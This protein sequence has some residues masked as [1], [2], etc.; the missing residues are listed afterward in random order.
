[1]GNRTD[2]L[3]SRAKVARRKDFDLAGFH[4]WLTTL[5]AADQRVWKDSPPHLELLQAFENDTYM[6]RGLATYLCLSPQNPALG[7]A[8]NAVMQSLQKR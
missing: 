4:K 2:S 7:E 8:Q 5:D 3:W 1:M 6:L